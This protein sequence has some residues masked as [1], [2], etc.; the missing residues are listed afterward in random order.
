MSRFYKSKRA[1]STLDYPFDWTN[2]DWLE[3][4]ESIISSVWVA[5]QEGITIVTTS[6]TATTTTV[7]VSGGT[8]GE[9]YKFINT[10]TTDNSPQRIDSRELFITI[11]P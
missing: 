11:A 2:E 5:V 9:T 4:N 3:A 10:I 1:D 7:W 6:F 8:A